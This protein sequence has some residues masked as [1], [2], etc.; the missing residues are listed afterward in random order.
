MGIQSINVAERLVQNW[1]PAYAGMTIWAIDYAAFI[2]RSTSS[3]SFTNAPVNT[4]GLDTWGAAPPNSQHPGG[5][6]MGMAD[7]SVKLIKDTVNLQTWWA[8]GTRN[9]NEVISADSL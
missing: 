4:W 7:G 2:N 1:I 3:T 8:V 5:V 9:G 6:N